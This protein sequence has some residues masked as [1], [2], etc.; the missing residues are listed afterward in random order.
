MQQSES[1][2]WL[3]A[4][5]QPVTGIG[6]TL[7]VFV[8][9]V[10]G[11]VLDADRAHSERDARRHGENLTSLL[12]Q[13][14]GRSFK[15]ADNTLLMLRRSYRT[16]PAR[17]NLSRWVLDQD[18]KNDLLTMLGIVGPDGKVR[19]SSYDD[20]PI[21]M[22]V[23]DR[24]HFIVQAE[25]KTDELFVSK[26]L[27]L[28]SSGKQ[29]I[30]LSRRV[31]NADGSFGGVITAAFDV[32]Q[33][34]TFY[35]ALDLG[36]GGLATLIGLDGTVRAAGANG[37]SRFDLIGRVFPRSGVLA[38]AQTAPAGSYWNEPGSNANS[39]RVD[40]QRRLMSYRRVEGL[41]LL[42]TV[43]VSEATVF[44]HARDN[45]RIYWFIFS[46]LA[47]GVVIAIG[48]TTWRECKLIAERR[49]HARALQAQF[50]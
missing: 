16:D 34:D 36:E 40:G 39:G 26:P 45:A 29:V 31:A 10:I 2:I 33:L 17:V 6:V 11:Q 7:L 28:R 18:S 41:P 15:A 9:L 47:A 30:M 23:S 22:D 44:A 46:A 35:Q 38:M 42:V 49:A 25:A 3:R 5:A 37:Q 4:L 8:L 43:G 12:E 50:A 27:T 32:A 20:R 24:Q 21:G 14:V 48:Y 13:F 19:S 1:R